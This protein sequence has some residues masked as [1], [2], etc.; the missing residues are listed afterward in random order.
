MKTDITKEDL[1]KFFETHDASKVM[2]T[3]DPKD[4]DLEELIEESTI[5]L[6]E[7]MLLEEYGEGILSTAAADSVADAAVVEAET[8]PVQ[9]EAELEAAMV[10][11][12][13]EIEKFMA[14]K[15]AEAK[16]EQAREAG[17]GVGD[18]TD[19]ETTAESA[20]S[21]PAPAPLSDQNSPSALASAVPASSA[22]VR[23]AADSVAEASEA[24]A[25]TTP[26]QTEAELE[27]AMVA[28]EAEIEKFMA[29]KEAEAKEEQAREAEAGAE[30]AAAAAAGAAGAAGEA[31][32]AAAAAA[33]AGAGAEG[34]GAVEATNA[35]TTGAQV[36]G[37]AKDIPAVSAGVKSYVAMQCKLDELTVAKAAAVVA[38]CPDGYTVRR[39]GETGE[40]DE[41]AERWLKVEI[42]AGE[43]P[44]STTVDYFKREFGDASS[45]APRDVAL[46]KQACDRIHLVMHSATGEPAGTA[47]VWLGERPRAV[48]EAKGSPA[49][50]TGWIHE[51]GVSAHHQGNGLGKL[52]SAACICRAK[53]LGHAEIFLITKTHAA[54]AVAM[55]R[56]V[57]FRP[58]IRAERGVGATARCSDQCLGEV[59]GFKPWC[60][61]WGGGADYDKQ[62]WCV[63]S[64]LTGIT[65][66]VGNGD[67]AGA[68]MGQ[69]ELDAAIDADATAE[70]QADVDAA[71]VEDEDVDKEI[72]LS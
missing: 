45:V 12:E 38:A 18:V 1:K 44:P 39:F 8:T 60:G 29:R 21:D 43:L 57:G 31:G 53:E 30:G 13:A 41:D 20:A 10:A 24:E 71:G 5:P 46:C 61:R 69:A 55:Y 2:D 62:G 22:A 54:R 11:E 16:E 3:D 51:V 50:V 56:G 70:G 63:L 4:M 68:A 23:T 36:E 28:E 35:D 25:E 6:I 34:A 17:A 37:R 26:V 64:T 59:C 40:A 7:E 14:R 27:A 9:T 15:E 47:M 65:F 48:G 66:A 19:I 58:L 67:E 42:E 49:Y 33:G 52:V 72:D 32:A